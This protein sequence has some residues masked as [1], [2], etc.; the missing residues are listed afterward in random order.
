MT[1]ESNEADV[2][3][4]MLTLQ[5]KILPHKLRDCHTE[6]LITKVIISAV[7]Y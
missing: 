5:S 6:N 4:I 1:L 2:S 7:L 3:H